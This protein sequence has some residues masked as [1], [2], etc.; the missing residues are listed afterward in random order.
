MDFSFVGLSHFVHLFWGAHFNLL[1]VS[2]H[3]DVDEDAY[4]IHTNLAV[5]AEV[6]VAQASEHLAFAPGWS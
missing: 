5:F 2:F 1:I 6:L 4:Q 3:I